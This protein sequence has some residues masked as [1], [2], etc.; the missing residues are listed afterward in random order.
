MSHLHK[1]LEEPK[2]L[3]KMNEKGDLIELLIAFFATIGFGPIV[4]V[5]VSIVL[6]VLEF[7]YRS[8]TPHVGIEG[9]VA[10]TNLYKDTSIYPGT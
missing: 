4:G 3:W 10:E 8:A 5:V 6:A 2:F 7:V 1:S 9:R